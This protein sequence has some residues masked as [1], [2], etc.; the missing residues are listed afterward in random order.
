[1]ANFT[2]TYLGGAGLMGIQVT[3]ASVNATSVHY[4]LGDGTTTTYK[5]FKYTYWQAGT[6]TIK[7]TATNA[8]G[9]ATKTI[10]VTVPASGSRTS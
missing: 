4:D 7:L 2:V 5:N 1:M 9:S 10:S 8:T 6:Y 3:D